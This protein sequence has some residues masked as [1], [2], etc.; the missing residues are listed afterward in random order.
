MPNKWLN[1]K[2]IEI[3]KQKYKVSNWSDYNK[4]L[5][6][7]GDVEIWLSQHLINHW[8]YEERIYDGTGSSKD[9]TDE[10]IIVCHE[11]RQSRHLLIS[12]VDPIGFV[13]ILLSMFFEDQ[14]STII[15]RLGLS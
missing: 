15:R 5:K 14:R 2:D 13:K 11:L 7:R 9:Y 6:N 1:Q 3:N 8:H 10:A 4:S 12:M